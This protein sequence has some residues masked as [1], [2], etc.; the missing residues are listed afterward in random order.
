MSDVQMTELTRH[1]YEFHDIL[2][3]VEAV[4]FLTFINK[5]EKIMLGELVKQRI[6]DFLINGKLSLDGNIFLNN[7][8]TGDMEETTR[9]NDILQIYKH[10]NESMENVVETVTPGKET[11]TKPQDPYYINK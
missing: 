3:E 8:K 2:T 10:E 4:S 9:K 11:M 5:E 6:V 1:L 7:D